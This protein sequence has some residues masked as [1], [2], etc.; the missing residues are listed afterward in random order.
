M[1]NTAANTLNYSDVSKSYLAGC[2]MVWYQRNV[3]LGEKNGVQFIED[4]GDQQHARFLLF[5]H[6]FL[7][8]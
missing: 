2:G 5:W 8:R 7:Q 3:A 4:G 6:C 1:I